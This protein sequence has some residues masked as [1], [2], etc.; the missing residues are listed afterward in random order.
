MSN[1]L[2]GAINEGVEI[3]RTAGE[4]VADELK[5]ELKDI[6]RSITAV[7]TKLVKGEMDRTE[8]ELT[9]GNLIRA[10]ESKGIIALVDK[11]RRIIQGA[12]RITTNVLT[13]LAAGV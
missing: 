5:N 2:L 4:D 9:I 13:H 10:G 7:G 8:A 3:L 11:E 1:V 12:I 6:A